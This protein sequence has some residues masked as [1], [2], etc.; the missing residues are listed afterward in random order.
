MR[1]R[2]VYA[3]FTNARVGDDARCQTDIAVRHDNLRGFTVISRSAAEF[4]AIMT[5]FVVAEVHPFSDGNGRTARL[6]MNCMLS[7][8][9]LSR[10]INSNGL[11]GRLP[12]GSE[13][14]EPQPHCRAQGLGRRSRALLGRQPLIRV[15][16][17][18]GTS[19][20]VWILSLGRI[21][22]PQATP[23]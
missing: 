19:V 18:P 1:I 22:R 14:A 17:D 15:W 4:Q 11:P 9:A 13:G 10:I 7:A 3:R 20:M 5:M 12:A 2:A 23:W 8:R 16:S 6:A 21:R